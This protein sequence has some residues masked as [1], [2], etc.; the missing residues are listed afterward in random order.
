[1]IGKIRIAREWGT[2]VTSSVLS[3]SRE[4]NQTSNEGDNEN[5]EI[6][7][8]SMCCEEITDTCPTS[9]QPTNTTPAETSKSSTANQERIIAIEVNSNASKEVI[10]SPDNNE[11]ASIPTEPEVVTSPSSVNIP[12]KQ[13][14]P[15]GIKIVAG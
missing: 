5:F 15:V 6:I 11:S 13:W 10:G 7:D 3:T 8:A 12:V 4:S 9:D 14:D 1:M 2:L